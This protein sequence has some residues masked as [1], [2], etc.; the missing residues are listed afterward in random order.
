VRRS[1]DYS[2]EGLVRDRTEV[3]H[4]EALSTQNGVKFVEG[5]AG[6]GDDKTFFPVDLF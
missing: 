3:G 2:R 6:L 4:G 1:G 5:D